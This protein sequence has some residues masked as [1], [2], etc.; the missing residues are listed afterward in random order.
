MTY[1]S[2]KYVISNILNYVHNFANRRSPISLPYTERSIYNI[3][4]LILNYYFYVYLTNF[5]RLRFGFNKPG[6]FPTFKVD[7]I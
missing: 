4:L 2:F 6:H 7:I 3:C 5:V 1:N